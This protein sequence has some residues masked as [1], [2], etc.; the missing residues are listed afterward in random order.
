MKSF[1]LIIAGGRNYTNYDNVKEQL[2]HLLRD[3]NADDIEIVSGA[4]STGKLTFTRKDGTK[5]YGADGLGERIAEEKDFPVKLFPADWKQHG[6]SAG[7]KRNKE[8]SEYATHCICFWD[9]KSRGTEMMIEL[10][11][12][13]ELGLTVINY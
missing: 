1:R 5:V 11:E 8:M 12:K 10:A 9:G 3:V 13:K 2:Y 4:C 6:M 7:Y